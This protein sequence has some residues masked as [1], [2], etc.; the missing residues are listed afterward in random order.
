MKKKRAYVKGQKAKE[1][2]VTGGAFGALLKRSWR[3]AIGFW[4]VCGEAG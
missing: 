4:R 3:K 2:K 1:S